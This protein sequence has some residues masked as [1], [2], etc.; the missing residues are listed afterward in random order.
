MYLTRKGIEDIEQWS[1]AGIELPNY[2][3][4]NMVHT[5]NMHPNWIHF[6]AGNIF[7]G[8][9]AA[10]Q[11]KLLNKGKADTGIIVAESYDL[12]IIEKIYKPYDN[13]SLL[14][15]MEPGGALRKEVIASVAESIQIQPMQTGIGWKR[16]QEIFMCPSLQIVSFTITEKGYSLTGLSGELLPVAAED[17]VN[18]PVQPKHTMAIAASLAYVRYRAGKLPIAFVSMDNCSGNGEKLYNSVCKISTA[19]IEKGFVEPEFLDYLKD[20]SRVSFPWSMIDKITP[21]PSDFVKTELESLKVCNMDIAVTGMKTNIAPFVNAEVTQYLVV[22]DAF[23]NGRPP[24]EDAG[25]IFTNRETVEKTEK[26][27]VGTCLNPLHTALAIY[28]CLLGYRS[29][30]DEMKDPD[31]K[32]LVERIAF[33]EGMPVVVDPGI[34]RPQDFVREVIEE[35]FPNPYIPDTPQRIAADT[36]QK[37]PVRFGGTIRAYMEQPALDAGSLIYI[38]LVIAGWCRYLLGIDDEGNKMPVSPDP[39]LQQLRAYL[40]GIEVGDLNTYN[41]QL[42]PILSNSTLFN[43][44]LYEAGLGEKIEEMFKQLIAGSHS[45][46]DTLKHYLDSDII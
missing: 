13:L 11:Q 37:M 2:D 27:K 17:M 39:M 6:G 28:G 26:M 18:G 10:L 7:R 8:F 43:L 19:W 4:D 1:N 29:I 33:K 41:G 45:V 20:P 24:L 36:S 5:T 34:I 21:H 15:L 23:P 12:E 16:L 46:R 9:T 35:R 25:V 3:V 14:V 31:L 40:D 22:E 38:P 30:S 32:Q 42:A 44:N